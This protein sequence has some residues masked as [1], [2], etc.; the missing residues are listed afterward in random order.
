M[1]VFYDN[2][3]SVSKTKKFIIGAL[4]LSTVLLA[5]W[6][7]YVLIYHNKQPTEINVKYSFYDFVYDNSIGVTKSVI[8]GN[9]NKFKNFLPQ[10]SI[11][12]INTIN[13]E[14]Q[15]IVIQKVDRFMSCIIEKQLNRIIEVLETFKSRSVPLIIKQLILSIFN[16]SI[17][18]VLNFT[19]NCTV[20]LFLVVTGMP[21]RVF[22]FLTSPISYILTAYFQGSEL[23]NRVMTWLKTIGSLL[24]YSKLLIL[25]CLTILLLYLSHKV[26]FK[27]LNK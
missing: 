26:L 13:Y 2:I 23:F 9:I 16:I 17:K 1:H 18:P 3:N 8:I 14:I 6:F 7:S 24:E 15:R 12:L 27:F 4:V 25:F 22:K 19:H 21:M 20:G 10:S 5:M 11:I